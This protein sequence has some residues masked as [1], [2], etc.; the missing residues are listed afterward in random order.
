[1]CSGHSAGEKQSNDQKLIFHPLQL[2]KLKAVWGQAGQRW[3]GAGAVLGEAQ[4]SASCHLMTY[5]TEPVL[6]VGMGEALRFSP[7]KRVCV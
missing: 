4:C 2:L 6:K 7:W 5:K 1:M 3:A